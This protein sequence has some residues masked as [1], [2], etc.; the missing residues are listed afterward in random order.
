MNMRMV[1]MKRTQVNRRA[2][3]RGV[4]TVAIGLPFLEGLPSRSAWAAGEEPVFSFFIMTQNGVVQENFWPSATGALTE[5]TM[6]GKAVEKIS[7]FAENLLMIKGLKLPGGGSNCSHAQGCV[8]VMTGAAPASAGNSSTAGGPSID[9]V[10]S[11]ALNPAGTDPLT[12]YAGA[13]NGAYIAERLSFSSAGTPARSA[14]LNPYETYKKLVNLVDTTSPTS[15]APTGTG[16]GVVTGPSAA[17]ELLLRQK[18]VND[19]VRDE[20]KSL[21]GR[22]DLSTEDVRRLQ[23]HM[24]GIRQLEANIV[25]TGETMNE[26]NEGSPETATPTGSSEC[27][28]G[29]LNVT[30][31]DAFKNGVT[32]NQ[33]GHMIEDLV[34][35]H[36]ET[37]A[38][39]FACNFNR[40]ATLQWGEGTAPTIYNTSATG[41]YNQFH[42]ISHRTNSDASSGNDG[43]AKEA[44]IE[45]DRIRMETFAHVL[46][47]FKDRGL[48]DRSFIYLT[49]SIADGPSH[50]F[51]PVPI[52]IAGNGGGFFRQGEYINGNGNNSTLLASMATAAGVPT[53]NFGAGGGQFT[54]AHV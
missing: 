48:F 39:A 27:A 22:S 4:G 13:F 54:A 2:F 18:S 45:I 53:E 17:D 46:Q 28:V 51:G 1:P 14:Q 11:K 6:A 12:L 20:F 25:S 5:A 35:L 32:Y 29:N 8:Q 44:H 21:L 30:G 16:G 47:H 52:I 26:V 42:K 7:A 41:G 49:N 24:D 33:A 3:L 37:V 23:S 15:P 10:I 19:L 40:T 36:G 38:L 50:A 34:K 9:M 43:W 31:L